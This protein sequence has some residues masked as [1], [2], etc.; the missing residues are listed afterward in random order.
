MGRQVVPGRSDGGPLSGAGRWPGPD[1]VGRR[2]RRDR[3]RHQVNERKTEWRSKAKAER[4]EIPIDHRRFCLVLADFLEGNVAAE[5]R[6]VVYRAMND[7][8]DLEDL[9]DGHPRPKDR[10]AVTRTPDTGLALTIHPWGG[11]EERHAFGYLQPL[12]GAPIVGDD[13]IGAVLVPGLAFDRSGTRLGRGKGYYDRFLPRMPSPCL[14]IGITSDYLV[15]RLPAEDFDVAM[16]HLAF[17]DGI[18][19]VPLSDS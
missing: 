2:W 19:A 13:K 8:V 16:T 7:E 1:N 9:V 11:P 14:F 15:E 18:R 12:A 10:F 17:S 6:V 3:S 5:S 4:A